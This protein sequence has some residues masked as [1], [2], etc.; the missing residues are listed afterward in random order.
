M[1]KTLNTPPDQP[2]GRKAA[3][4]FSGGQDSTTCLFW[5]LQHFDS[6]SLLSFDYGQ[7]HAAELDAA[8]RV[9]KRVDLPLTIIPVASLKALG[10]N[11]LTD[12]A[13][14]VSAA[15]TARGLPN[16][17]VPGRNLVF[18]TLL[19]AFAYQRGIQDLVAGVCQTDYSGYPDCRLD[20]MKAL[21][22]SLSLGMDES[23]RIH[24]PLMHLDKAETVKLALSLPGCYEALGDSHT[25]YKGQR[26]PCQDCP[27]CELRARGF[28][29][30]GVEDP[31]LS[32]SG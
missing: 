28:Q 9:A 18:L 29:Q 32:S 16:S 6:V 4:S 19:A 25:C 30:A 5:A 23:F 14:E 27:A 11:S 12:D 7:R 2:L 24:T 26:P 8:R 13:I 3:L 1:T 21:E 22:Q 17:F 20:T 31:V 10:G 15:M